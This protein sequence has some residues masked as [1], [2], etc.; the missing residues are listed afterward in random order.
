MGKI[1]K[2]LF[3]AG[4]TNQVVCDKC[5]KYKFKDELTK[6]RHCG[7]NFCDWHGNRKEERCESCI[8]KREKYPDSDGYFWQ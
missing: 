5:N 1:R 6:C 4:I 8:M 2:F 3:E 7:C